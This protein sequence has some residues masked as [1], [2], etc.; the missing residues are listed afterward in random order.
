[1][2]T[3]FKEEHKFH[4]QV[5]AWYQPDGIDGSRLRECVG[6]IINIER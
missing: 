3:Y 1:M 5:G 2:Q 6:G 4:T